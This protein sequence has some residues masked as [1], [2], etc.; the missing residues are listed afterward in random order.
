MRRIITILFLSYSSTCFSFELKLDC[1]VKSTYTY[2]SGSVERSV[3]KALIEVRESSTDTLIVVSSAIDMVNDL[4]VA[5]FQAENRSI[6]NLS[7][8][9]KW[10]IKTT[11][12][13]ADR[14]SVTGILIDRN[15]GMLI[16]E[17][18]YN[19]NGRISTTQVSGT[20]SKIDTTRRKF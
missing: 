8:S 10:H 4:S 2:S 20:C 17:R 16:I 9:N 18:T 15:S 14:V 19:N 12:T 6:Q 5:T 13:R 11:I 7:D 3:G 1:D